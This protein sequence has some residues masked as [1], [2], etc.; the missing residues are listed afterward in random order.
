MS[1]DS[2]AG[3][4]LNVVCGLL[5][6][7]VAPMSPTAFFERLHHPLSPSQIALQESLADLFGCASLLFNEVLERLQGDKAAGHPI[8]PAQVGV[9]GELAIKDP[10]LGPLSVRLF[11]EINGGKD[12]FGLFHGPRQAQDHRSRASRRVQC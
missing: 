6:A 4:S 1:F 7:A 8:Q 9:G 12:L 3:E 10:L 2:T 11:P 5:C